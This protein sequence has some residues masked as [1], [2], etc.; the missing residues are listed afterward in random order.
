VRV[1]IVGAGAVGLGIGSFLLA[2][3]SEVRFVVR[4]ADDRGV[5]ARH[6]LSRLGIFGATE[7]PPGAFSLVNR[8][9]D[10]RGS[11]LDYLL[12]CSKTTSSRD[13]AEAL[14][15]I[16]RDFPAPPPVVLCQNGWGNTEIFGERIPPASVFNARIITGFRRDAPNRVEITVHAEPIHLGSLLGGCLGV[17]QPLRDALASTGM[18]C[19][20]SESIERDLWAKMLYNC[21]LNPLG[22]LLGVPYGE[23]AARD[24][25]REIVEAVIREIFRVLA[26]AG[27]ATHW[28]T[29]AEYLQTF[30]ADL[31]PPTAAHESSMLQD[32]R[33]G[34][35][36]EIDALCGAVSRL[37]AQHGIATPVNGALSE[38]IHAL[39]ANRGEQ[40]D[41]GELL[42]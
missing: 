19:E 36:S 3:G 39:E 17:L 14:G 4:N 20:L 33:A 27:Y 12:V 18:P 25:S 26:P 16:W 2:A 32:I 1:A 11:E 8:V 10:L 15:D 6:G 5:L 7:D 30:Y 34:R 22:A 9:A 40:A 35:R 24:S 21:A 28:N 31:L 38:L 13:I 29:S 42:D 23:L 37:G 41:P